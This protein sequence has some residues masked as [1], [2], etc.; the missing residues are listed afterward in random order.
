M[1]SEEPKASMS[2]LRDILD[3]VLGMAAALPRGLDTPAEFGL[4][5][6]AGL[7]ILNDADVQACPADSRQA[8]EPSVL[9][10]IHDH[11]GSPG[12]R[13]RLLP[14]GAAHAGDA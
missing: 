4:C 7:Q 2:T 10:R 9:I 1:A 6:G 3:A 5:D 11:P 14:G 13:G 8:G 12:S